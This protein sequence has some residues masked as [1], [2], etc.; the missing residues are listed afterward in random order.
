M[1]EIVSIGQSRHRLPAALRS[2][3]RSGRQS[4]AV[5]NVPSKKG[6]YIFSA[7]HGRPDPA[8]PAVIVLVLF[9]LIYGIYCIHT[10]S[11]T[12]VDFSPDEQN[13][14]TMAQR[15]LRDHIYS[16]WGNGPDAYVPPGYPLYLAGCLAVFGD[17]PLSFYHIRLFQCTLFAVTVL[18][19]FL[20]GRSLTD[21]ARVGLFA[22][23][24]VSF[25]GV[26]YGYLTRMLTEPVYLF[27][28]MLF[29][30]V[31]VQ[32]VRRGKKLL[33]LLAGL[34]FAGTVFIRPMII[35]VAPFLY[36]P[37]WIR[38]RKQIR[39]E[40]M[41]TVFFG[42]GFLLPALP[43]WLRNLIVL[44][45]FV[46]LATQTNP[47]F[48]GLVPDTFLSMF[49]DPGSFSGNL[50]LF[51]Y[52]LKADFTGTLRWMTLDKYRIFFHSN[53]YY[54]HFPHLSVFV[55]E[56]TLVSGFVGGLVALFSR[57]LRPFALVFWIYLLISFLF[58][59]T[60]RYAL[61]YYPWLAVLGACFLCGIPA[62][63]AKRKKTLHGS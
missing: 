25:N 7:G 40:I 2:R 30:V 37:L 57:K 47:F 31:F 56:I 54:Y 8:W 18:L 11:Y 22:A 16:F 62:K 38:G 21:S 39:R 27:F 51:F 50:R 41:N 5:R 23:A 55:K 42:I 15:L 10:F 44:H 36:L 53:I 3:A 43:W 46:L 29:L 58:V 60:E 33:H 34:L 28:M 13:Y 19:S 4:S 6:K 9:T 63:L 48:A 52:C 20:L 35:I 45:Q 32:A 26:F 1:T 14:I 12:S 59:P 17:A 61:Q 49:Q 24:M